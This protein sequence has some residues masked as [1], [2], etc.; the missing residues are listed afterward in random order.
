MRDNGF[1]PRNNP[2]LEPI[3]TIRHMDAIL[4]TSD[5]EHPKE[6][7]WLAAESRCILP[8]PSAFSP[9]AFVPKSSTSLRNWMFGLR[10]FRLIARPIS[11]DF[12]NI[13]VV[14]APGD[15]TTAAGRVFVF[16]AITGSPLTYLNNPD[17]GSFYNFGRAVAVSGDTVVVGAFGH[18]GDFGAP[19]RAFVF[20]ALTGALVATLTSPDPVA[21]HFGFSVAVSGDMVVVGDHAA[22]A[23]D[24]GAAGSAYVFDA[25]SG[26]LV[27]TLT[28]PEP[29][30]KD[31]FGWSVSASDNTVVVGGLRAG[32]AYVYDGT[33]G[34]LLDTLI[35]PT[36]AVD[37]FFGSSVAISG[38]TV[39]VG[40]FNDDTQ[41]TNSGAAYVYAL[42]TGIV[43]MRDDPCDTGNTMLVAWGTSGN[44]RIVFKP[45]AVPGEVVV[46]INGTSNGPFA[47]TGRLVAYGL[48]EE[49]EI[50]VNNLDKPAWLYGDDG[51]DTLYGASGAD[52]LLGGSGNDALFGRGGRDILIGGAGED[53]VNGG[54]GD[55]IMI[56]GTTAFDANAIALCLIQAEWTSSRTF[57]RR[58]DNLHGI[59]NETFAHRANADYYLTVGSGRTVYD[60]DAHDHLSGGNDNCWFFGNVAGPSDLDDILDFGGK[61]VLDD[62]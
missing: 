51:N 59:S 22:T 11:G 58:V 39:V 15:D 49:D 25:P 7:E 26:A 54:A 32:S 35:D 37:D 46:V 9:T 56:S 17:P 34:S 5:P 3:E 4:D 48:G 36:P 21:S 47:P 62:L 28:N 40:A 16:D 31:F 60:D 20:D 6:P 53:E 27:A 33:S 24:I 13:V 45:G 61:D 38:N 23:G 52:V 43:E 57:A 10:T 8:S 50:R 14:G 42:K 19:G 18:V 30:S 55:D 12:W 44:D 29:G 1:A 41:N 2:V